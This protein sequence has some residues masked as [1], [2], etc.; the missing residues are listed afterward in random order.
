MFCDAGSLHAA[1]SAF[2]VDVDGITWTVTRC[3][4]GEPWQ[5]QQPR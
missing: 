3:I 4:T 1:S 2:I 5:Q